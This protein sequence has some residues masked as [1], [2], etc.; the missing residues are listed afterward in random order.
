MLQVV[1]SLRRSRHAAPT[2][3][4]SL[5]LLHGARQSGAMLRSRV[6]IKPNVSDVAHN[7]EAYQMMNEANTPAHPMAIVPEPARLSVGS[8]GSVTVELPH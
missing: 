3:R 4:A 6:Q 2:E 5:R 1:C 8:D 7:D